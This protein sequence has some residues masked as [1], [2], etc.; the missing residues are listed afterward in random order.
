MSS[1]LIKLIDSAILPAA[2]L[3]LGKVLGLYLT[4]QFFN[5]E[6]QV[7]FVNGSLI[8][9]YPV[10]F[11]K[12][13]LTAST[14]SDFIM[15]FVMIIGLIWITIRANFFHNSHVDP[16]LV[17]RLAGMNM[18]ELIKDSF[19][20]YHSAAMWVTFTCAAELMIIVNTIMGKT[21]LWVP[22]IGLLAIIVTLVVLLKD[23]ENELEREKKNLAI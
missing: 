6:W 19:K 14:Y 7:N 1:S 3:V 9:V 4:I 22:I 2:F 18:L 23:V 12:D 15:L 21:Q 8:S 11:E 20:I 10:V 16:R 5:L 13:L 17:A